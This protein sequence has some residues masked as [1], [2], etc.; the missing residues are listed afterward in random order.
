MKTAER[1]LLNDLGH[2]IRAIRRTQHKRFMHYVFGFNSIEAI[3]NGKCSKV[4]GRTRASQIEALNARVDF[5]QEDLQWVRD[6]QG[7]GR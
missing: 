1:K 4:W 7:A 2:T 3:L 5:I 6:P